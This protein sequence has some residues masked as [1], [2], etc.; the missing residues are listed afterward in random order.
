MPAIF[1]PQTPV[2]NDTGAIT[3]GLQGAP[4][5]LYDRTMVG[6]TAYTISTTGT[7]GGETMSLT[8]R[9]A[10]TYSFASSAPINWAGG[11]APTPE[12]SGS[13]FDRIK[14]EVLQD[15]ALLGTAQAL[16]ASSPTV[17]PTHYLNVSGVNQNAYAPATAANDGTDN[18]IS[19]HD[20][21]NLTSTYTPTEVAPLI[22]RWNTADAT[23]SNTEYI[24]CLSS[25]GVLQF[26][27]FDAS[28]N[29]QTVKSTEGISSVLANVAGIWLRMDY[30][31]GT[32]IVNGVPPGTAI[33]YTSPGGPNPTWTQLG[34]EVTG[35]Q[36]GL[37]HL[38][39]SSA[40]IVFGDTNQTGW[41]T[42]TCYIYEATVQNSTTILANPNFHVQPTTASG[43]FVDTAATPNTITLNT[44]IV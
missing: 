5:V 1:A 28:G 6:N 31:A 37:S 16:G 44:N 27:Y 18:F 22:A 15:G 35:E 20:W 29:V 8:L 23:S 38:G 43:S 39:A 2:T 9:G 24:F 36:T 32:E 30:N 19:F 42:N 14:F 13:A 3:L 10:Y 34:A 26:T 40:P 25:G 7:T 41:T 17:P 21:L 33:F 12:C 4:N 11:V